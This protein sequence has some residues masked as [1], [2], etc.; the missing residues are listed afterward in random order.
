M[1]WPGSVLGN[2][3]GV[4]SL[5]S[6]LL[7]CF[8]LGVLAAL[9]L[10]LATQDADAS[11]HFPGFRASSPR[12]SA[13]RQGALLSGLFACSAMAATWGWL[14]VSMHRYGG[15]PS[16]LA[17]LAVLFLAQSVAALWGF[18]EWNHSRIRLVADV[19][20]TVNEA[21]LVDVSQLDELQIHLFQSQHV[22]KLW[23]R[24]ERNL[25]E[26]FEGRLVMTEVLES[27]SLFFGGMAGSRMPIAVAHGEGFAEFSSTAAV[28]QALS[29]KL[30]S[31]RYVDHDG[32]PTEVYPRNPNG[33]PRGIT[34]L[35]TPDGRFSIMMPHPE[36]VFRAV[37]YSWRPDGW[38][39]DGPWMR[40]FRN[41][42]QVVA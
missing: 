42:R 29:Q 2:A 16:W 5:S 40:M 19:E 33:S 35:T 10:Q 20:S 18:A 9:L 11:H 13:W 7:Q 26:Q 21:P 24:F 31:V 36:R 34:G 6:G 17:A 4:T 37:Q 28:E 8:S 22:Q 12:Q 1:A 32:K 14:Y 30:V 27:P 23:P 15:M 41:A 25:S 39:E 3:L 38:H